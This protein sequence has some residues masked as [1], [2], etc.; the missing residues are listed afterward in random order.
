MRTKLAIVFIP[1]IASFVL[2]GCTGTPYQTVAPVQTQGAIH[3]DSSR[4]ADSIVA[5]KPSATVGSDAAAKESLK[6]CH[7]ETDDVA[8]ENCLVGTY[9]KLTGYKLKDTEYT[10]GTTDKGEFFKVSRD[11]KSSK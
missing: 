3:S 7:D 6:K 4:E 2:I 10:S 8:W 9:R 5:P 11:P 1:T